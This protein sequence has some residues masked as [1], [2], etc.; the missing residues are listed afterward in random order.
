MTL[1]SDLRINSSVVPVLPPCDKQKGCMMQIAVLFTDIVGSTRFFTSHG[2]LAGREMLQQ[3]EQLVSAAVTHHGGTLVK[4]VGDSAMAYFLSAEEALMSA[5]EIQQELRRYNQ[6]KDDRDPI[7]IRI[8]IHFGNGIIEQDDIFGSVVNIAAKLTPLVDPDQI[9]ISGHVYK[10]VS[11]LSAAD[12]EPVDLSGKKALPEGLTAYRV[13]WKETFRPESHSHP[14]DRPAID[15]PVQMWDVELIKLYQRTIAQG[16]NQ[17]CYYCGDRR[18]LTANCPSKHL[19]QKTNALEEL[20]YLSLGTINKLFWSLFASEKSNRP[21]N[22]DGM[23]INGPTTLANY[24][25][26]ELKRVFQLRFF[27]SIWNVKNESWSSIRKLSSD[28]DKGGPAWVALD[29]LRVSNLSKAESFLQKSLTQHPNDYRAHCV[30]GFLNVEKNDFGRSEHHW[31]RALECARTKPRKTLIY[32]LLFRLYHLNGY[33]SAAAEAIRE[34]LFLEPHCLEAI[35]ENILFK[36]RQGKTSEALRRLIKLIEQDRQ[37]YINALIDPELAPF[38]EMIHPELTRLFDEVKDEALRLSAKAEKKLSNLA[39]ILGA[40]K[41]AKAKSLLAKIEELSKSDGYLAYHDIIYYSESVIA[42]CQRCAENQRR[43]LL[44]A[45]YGVNRRLEQYCRAIGN[46]RYPSLANKIYQELKSIKRK[47]KELRDMTGLEVSEKFKEV[48]LSAEELSRK[49]DKI[50]IRLNKLR[51]IQDMVLF[52]RR[53]LK[54]SL[55]FE[56]VLIFFTMIFFPIVIYYLN[57]VLPKYN[58]SPVRDIWS[59]QKEIIGF[60]GI[61]ALVLA[62]V[63]TFSTSPKR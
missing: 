8:A 11:D 40:E 42:I 24:G 22:S 61:L 28:E 33:H 32:L 29:C 27:A 43:E 7:H 36:F 59:Y 56:S 37:F 48:A 9:F 23:A 17:P 45:L 2:D 13:I 58:M 53:F 19:P 38:S 16:K 5:I 54:K 47:I 1:Q 57:L 30:M 62:F 15:N 39:G 21:P 35:Y 31:Q 18:H 10:L 55:L 3:H 51:A 20:G 44:E 25:F 12:F 34:L 6:K 26:F 52:F 46:Y 50:E 14:V 4:I 63:K 60:G 41:V 49:L